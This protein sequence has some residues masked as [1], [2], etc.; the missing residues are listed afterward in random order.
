[1]LRILTIGDPHFKVSGVQEH[2][3]MIDAVLKITKEQSPDLIVVLGDVLD[4]HETIHVSPLSRAVRFLLE[5]AKISKTYVL[6]GNHDLKNNRQFLSKEHG[7][8]GLH[9]ENLIIV[10]EP[11]EAQKLIFCPYVPPGRF[12]EALAQIPNWQSARMIFAHQ[13]FRGANMEGIESAD[14]D[15]WDASYPTV[16]SGHIH[17]FQILQSNLIYPG[18]PMQHNFGDDPNKGLSL[19]TLGDTT[20]SHSRISLPL[21]RKIV[22]KITKADIETLILPEKSIVKIS[23]ICS[24]GE[25]RALRKHPK[26]KQWISEGVIVVY[27][28]ENE[29]KR[30]EGMVES[31]K[32]LVNFS[33]RVHE[34]IKDDAELINIYQELLR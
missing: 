13:E 26:I 29:S 19:F 18:T 20:I 34:Y 16:V 15:K 1:M 30:R 23:L 31:Q 27:C 21:R 14:G 22:I 2:E 24:L 9:Y 3:E 25:S 33:A 11:I 17:T 28:E 32:A 10:D 4:R 8:I 12:E 5:L 6:I 7:L